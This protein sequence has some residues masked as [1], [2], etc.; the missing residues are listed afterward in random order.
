VAGGN[1]LAAISELFV[2]YY[3]PEEETDASY[4]E[5]FDPVDGMVVHLNP[6]E[7]GEGH[8]DRMRDDFG[9]ADMPDKEGWMTKTISIENLEK[10][11]NNTHLCLTTNVYVPKANTQLMDGHQIFTWNKQATLSFMACADLRVPAVASSDD[12]HNVNEVRTTVHSSRVMV[13]VPTYALTIDETTL[14]LSDRIN[15]KITQVQQLPGLNFRALKCTVKC[16]TD[17]C[18]GKTMT[19]YGSDGNYC[20]DEFTDFQITS[21][22]T[23]APAEYSFVAFK[24][25]S[26]IVDPNDAE[27]EIPDEEQSLSCE[28]EHQTTDFD[29]IIPPICQ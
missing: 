27:E 17:H 13:W 15:F 10:E 22:G 12:P 16:K 29:P 9:Y 21:D 8:E 6:T 18:F 5:S 26:G 19:V 1:K 11:L 2:D 23:D 28:V 14:S 24:W 4:I 3:C 25:W 7:L 20:V